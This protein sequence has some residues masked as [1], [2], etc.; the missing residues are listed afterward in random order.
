MSEIRSR[1]LN[2][3]RATGFAVATRARHAVTIRSTSLKRA[4]MS[5]VSLYLSTCY[6]AGLIGQS[7]GGVY[8]TPS[9]SSS[10]CGDHAYIQL[11]INCAR[12][13]RFLHPCDINMIATAAVAPFAHA[14]V[15]AAEV[16]D[17]LRPRDH[18]HYVDGTVGGA[19]HAAL[20]LSGAPA[21]RLI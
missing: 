10:K 20:V 11:H 14:P 15:L 18:G 13:A 19:G 7:K 12:I 21:A 2:S 6:P 5:S 17:A 9:G 4:S 1:L 3:V 8:E 16:L